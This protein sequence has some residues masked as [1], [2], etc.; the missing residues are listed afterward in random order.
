VASDERTDQPT[1]RATDATALRSSDDPTLARAV[2]VADA[3]GVEPTVGLTAAE[4]ARRLEADGPNELR[5][6]RATPLWRR[7]LSQFQDPLIYLLLGAL[8]VALLAW[9][10]EGA[11][12]L[13]IDV[14]VIGAIVIINA[15][16][17]VVQEARADEAVA[18]LSRMTEANSLVLR[19]GE[20][21]TVPSSELVRGDVIVLGEG[22]QVGADAR[23]VE[24][25]GLRVAE[26][27]L[28]GESQP[29]DKH[30]RALEGPAELG[31]RT[32]MV[33]KG[34]AV[35]RGTG[36]AVVT[37][38]GMDTQMGSIA[39]MLEQTQEEK[40]PLQRE[41]GRVG[42]MLGIVV[43]AIAIVVMATII[44]VEGVT[45]PAD[46]VTVLL[47]GVSLAVAAVPEGLPA[48]M[49]VVLALGVQRMAK[50]KAVVRQLSSVETLGA[51][52][53][54]CSDKTGTLTTNE[55]TVQRIVTAS[56]TV[57]LAGVG[58]APVGDVTSGGEPIG[59]GPLREEAQVVLAA[60][61]LA[62]DA[63][64][65][66]HDGEWSIQGDP[67]EAA[68]LVAARKLAGTVER[69]E[70]F[71]RVASVPFDSERKMMSTANRHLDE[72]V[73]VL[74]SKGAPD[75]LLERCTAIRIGDDAVPL[76]DERREQALADVHG[77]T[78][79]AYRTLGVAYR[80]QPDL[81]IETDAPEL[82]ESVEHDLIYV[83]VV[84]I[85]DPARPE[86]KPSI[87]EAHRAGIRVLM[88]TGDHPETAARIAADL[89]IVEPGAEAVVGRELGELDDEALRRTV[90]DHSVYA[91]VAPEHKLRIVD[92]LQADGQ[93]IAMTGDGVNDAPALKSA[94]IGVAMGITGT[95]VT[96]QAAKMILGDDDFATIV[97]A[98]R[99]GRVIFDNIKKFLRYL[100][101]S[102][103][104]EVMTVFFGV[105]FAG[106]LGL[107]GATDE[108]VVAPLLATQ[109]LWMNL[110]TDSGP[111][112][113]MGVDPE[114][115]DVMA[116]KPRGVDD[117]AIDGRMWVGIFIT[118]AVMAVAALGVM[119]LFLPGGLIPGGDDSIEVART[120]AFTTLVFAAMLTAFNARS[121]THSA[122]FRPFSNRWLLGAVAL[123]VVLQ[124]AVVE[125]PFLQVAFG[126]AHLSAEHWIACV[127]AATLVLWVSEVQKVALRARDRAR[128]GAASADLL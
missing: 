124:V 100:L 33:F 20:R 80:E 57:E 86:A 15:I 40:T 75:V 48:I 24:S 72:D 9:V 120:A 31:D 96:K 107:A 65:T 110:I 43:I 119:D 82:D 99:E 118:G 16:I 7:I 14:I 105:V 45:Q 106:V 36:L 79:Q 52:S 19:D 3:L 17:G 50:R 4:A 39:T 61:S 56:G 73:S 63:A 125:V 2:E 126:T 32:N 122:F 81:P 101:F 34:T 37:A 103:M 74:F 127:V 11:E 21:G 109:I 55:M 67:T 85:I 41:I 89:G 59:D 18:A 68:F 66:E 111:A 108:A 26:A 35:N 91:R 78:R 113:A 12:G 53:A 102:N 93:V 71:E 115:D 13:P 64:L 49:S 25:S 62:N 54:I 28:T 128:A 114:I 23:L 123:S 8:L 84:G 22:D 117:R 104:G 69:A 112:L 88:I 1:D 92:A 94:D 70:R 87:A 76:T 27:S 51:A 60:G 30:P 98:V 29:V 46:L 121:E 97:A 6:A 10:L 77:L 90:H 95:E 5:E 47:L 58:Y 83:G 42:R 44:I 38:T 116:R